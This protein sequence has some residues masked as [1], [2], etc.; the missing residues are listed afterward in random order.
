MTKPA[1]VR[2]LAEVRQALAPLH[3]FHVSATPSEKTLVSWVD[4]PPTKKVMNFLLASTSAGLTDR[5]TLE[6][7]LSPPVWA[8]FCRSVPA[9][10]YVA[11]ARSAISQPAPT[12]SPRDVLVAEIGL[13]AA[14]RAPRV[15]SDNSQTFLMYHMVHRVHLL[16]SGLSDESVEVLHRLSLDSPDAS[17]E[18]LL[19]M[20]RLLGVSP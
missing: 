9:E 13:R 6:R 7:R 5:T 8:A 12:P 10:R 19:E 3:K 15:S 14:G 11:I 4:G 18:S 20:A 2:D 16:T 1:V 17:L